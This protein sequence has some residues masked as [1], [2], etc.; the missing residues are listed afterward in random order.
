[1]CG[2]AGDGGA[3]AFERLAQR[4]QR[5]A[6]ELRQLVQEQGAAVGQAELA[7]PGALAAVISTP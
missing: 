1:M 7:G 3:A 6:R 5:D 4:L 2:G